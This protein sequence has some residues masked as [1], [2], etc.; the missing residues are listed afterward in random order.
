MPAKLF[1]SSDIGSEAFDFP[2]ISPDLLFVRP[3]LAAWSMV[4][5]IKSQAVTVPVQLELLLPQ[6]LLIG[7]DVA[8]RTCLCGREDR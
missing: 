5:A 1:V 2:T 3:N 4:T 7:A 8:Q 6:T